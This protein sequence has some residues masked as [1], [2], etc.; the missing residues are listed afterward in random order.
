MTFAFQIKIF[1]SLHKITQPSIIRWFFFCSRRPLNITKTKFVTT[2]SSP[3]WLKASDN[4]DI[5]LL[6]SKKYPRTQEETSKHASL[7]KDWP[8]HYNSWYKDSIQLI[9]DSTI[10]RLCNKQLRATILI[11]MKPDR[12]RLILED[13]LF[14]T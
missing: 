8:A 9:S 4:G 14:I 1:N 12:L 5:T 3:I 10:E 7:V 11:T 6:S 13:R 2:E